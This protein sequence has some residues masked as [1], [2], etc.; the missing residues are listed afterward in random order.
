MNRTGSFTLALAALAVP[1]LVCAQAAS[2]PVGGEVMFVSGKAQRV[3]KDGQAIAVAKGMALLEGDRIKTDA[4]SH[5]YVRLRDGG[6]LVVRPA[7]ELHVDMW[8]Y[9]ASKPQDSQIKY[10]LD[11]G[12]ARHVSGQGA[13]SAR[14]KFRFNTPMAAIG[15]RGTDFTVSAD[16]GVTR[17][18]VRSGGVIVNSFG[19]GCRRDG[20]GPCEGASAVELFANASAK[21]LQ[22]RAGERRP[23]V[24]DDPAASPDRARPPATAEPVAK[25]PSNTTTDLHLADSRGSE[26]ADIDHPN[27]PGTPGTPGTP[28]PVPDAPIGAW[29]RYT[30][31]ASGDA[32]VVKV[33]DVLNGRQVVA[34]NR[35]YVLAANPSMTSFALP[36]DGVGNFTLVAHDGMITENT[37][38]VS[39]ASA[40]SNGKLSIDFGARRFS[41]SLDVGVGPISTTISAQ[42]SVDSAGRFQSDLFV[43]SSTISGLVGGRD[44]S[45]AM[46]LYERK[47]GSYTATGATSW[48]K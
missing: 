32:G 3:A 45:E 40:A 18:A 48:K 34:I 30:A 42:G 47:F 16:P 35:N 33:E 26:V 17:V 22:V 46:Y 38:G 14:E 28:N 13:K 5:V 19:D 41:T 27:T 23:E 21:L 2:S 7:S 36:G 39:V 37:S 25:S 4:D 1:A 15:V 8:R 20:V 10:T 24:I 44:A 12:V 31:I 6:L 9:D 43:S 29:G 11:N